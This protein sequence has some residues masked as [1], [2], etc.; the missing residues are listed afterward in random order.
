[1]TLLAMW[2]NGESVALA[3]DCKTT[4]PDGNV[5]EVPKQHLLP[6]GRVAFGF[7]FHGAHSW[8]TNCPCPKHRD[9]IGHWITCSQAEN[10]QALEQFIRKDLQAGKFPF[11]DATLSLC[12]VGFNKQGALEAFVLDGTGKRGKE[13]TQGEVWFSPKPLDE[14]GDRAFRCR[15]NLLELQRVEFPGVKALNE[16]CRQVVSFCHKKPDLTIG[17]GLDFCW[18]SLASDTLVCEERIHF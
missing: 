18:G 11:N 5:V 3:T 15:K 2:L 1:M 7:G 17:M 10:P 14:Q 13:L 16:A 9:Y 6:S 8:L 12:L 4:D